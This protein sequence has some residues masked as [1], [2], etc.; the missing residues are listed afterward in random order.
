MT[1]VRGSIENNSL[2]LEFGSIPSGFNIQRE[3]AII[4]PRDLICFQ[5]VLLSVRVIGSSQGET[6]AWG[7][8]LRYVDIDLFRRKA[9]CV[10]IYVLYLNFNHADLFVVGKHFH[11]EL[12]LGVLSAQCIPVDPL[13]SVWGGVLQHPE[14]GFFPLLSQFQFRILGNVSNDALNFLLRY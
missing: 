9:W 1:P 7:C 5:A 14:V 8:V 6:C 10:V 13:F 2:I 11:G 12:A 3:Y 4:I